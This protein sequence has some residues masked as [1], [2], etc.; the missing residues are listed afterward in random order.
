MQQRHQQPPEIIRSEDTFQR[1]RG[2]GVGLG[3]S[4]LIADEWDVGAGDAWFLS[5]GGIWPTAA[6]HLIYEG[7]FG[8]ASGHAGPE[9]DRWAF[10]LVG[11]TA[12]LTLATLS[13]SLGDMES[14]GAVLAHSGGALGLGLAQQRVAALNALGSDPA[15]WKR[16]D[17]EE[18]ADAVAERALSAGVYEKPAADG[19]PGKEL[20]VALNRAASEDS[21]QVLAKTSVDELFAGLDYRYLEDNLQE[22]RSVTSEI[23]RTFLMLMAAAMVLEAL[24]CIP[25]KRPETVVPVT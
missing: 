23:W 14:G 1:L 16:L 2:A 10:G 7:R 25:A 21:P 13:L 8:G 11:G 18:M 20:M 19:K 22:G 15:A 5:S 12:G 17:Q 9:G 6:A 3:A 24:L 4:L